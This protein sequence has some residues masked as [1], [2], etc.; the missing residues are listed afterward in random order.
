MAGERLSMQEQMQRRR[1]GGFVGRRD[2]LDTF[3]ANLDTDPAD[4]AHQF[5]FHVRGPGGVGKSTLLGRLE[6]TAGER[7]ALTATVN[8]TA[9]TVPETMGAVAARLAEQ[10]RPLKAF[11]RLLAAYHERRHDAESAGAAPPSAGSTIAAQVGLAGLGLVPGVG[12]LAGAVEPG[13]IAQGADR[14]RAALSARFR[15][16]QDVQLVLDPVSV[17][18]PVFTADLAAAA[19]GARW[20]TLFFDTYE[21]TGPVLDNW[22]CDLLI[23]GRYGALPANIVVTLAGQSALDRTVWADH[24]DLVTTLPL[25]PFTDAEARQVLAARGVTEEAVVETVLRLTGRLPLLV[26]TLAA[27]R[28]SGPGA[29]GDPADTA[30]ERFLKWERDPA[31]RAAA[32]AAALPLRLDEDVY[33]IAVAE[34]APEAADHYDW[35]RG[36]PFVDERSGHLRYHDIVRAQMLRLRRT[37][38]PQR[39]RDQHERLAAAFGVWRERAEDG[40]GVSELWADGTWREHR[41]HESYH[42]LCADHRTAL[43]DTLLDVARACTGGADTARHWIRMLTDA[44]QDTG[45]EELGEWARDLRGALDGT[46]GGGA[47]AQAPTARWRAGRAVHAVTVILERGGL[48]QARRATAQAIRAWTNLQAG[49]AQAA[50][51]DWDRAEQ[52]GLHTFVLYSERGSTHWSSGQPDQAVADYTRALPLAPDDAQALTTRVRRGGALLAAGRPEE[53]MTDLDAVIAADPGATPARAYR[54][55]ALLRLDRPADALADAEECLAAT[56]QGADDLALRGL[57]HQRLGHNAEAL[58]DFDHSLALQPDA[59]TW[60]FTGRGLA[61]EALGR[62]GEAADSFARAV[63]SGESA[64]A[65]TLAYYARVL[66]LAGR[67]TEALTVAE[68]AA[69]QHPGAA[70]PVREAAV[71]LYESG[72][73]PDAA[74]ALR[75]LLDLDPAAGYAL[76]SLALI[77]ARLGQPAAALADLDR[78]AEI[79]PPPPW[80]HARR[81]QLHVLLRD[82]AAARDELGALERDRALGVDELLT[83]AVCHREQRRY[84]DAAAVLARAGALE[85]GHDGVALE[86]AMLAALTDGFPAARG[87]WLAL[88]AA[89]EPP[90]SLAANAPALW[91]MLL[92]CGLGEWDAAGTHV[93]ALLAT[94]PSWATLTVLARDVAALAAAPAGHPDRLAPLLTRLPT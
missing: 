41:L 88:R 64:E 26:S 18:S 4:E 56:A 54:A 20:L 22:L 90:G 77:H 58:A 2:E 72:R 3:R 76:E 17:L 55:M 32:L 63:G 87:R 10:G 51:A 5:L 69:A 44:A 84:A 50:L 38:S 48:D 21:R 73:L 65:E 46:S 7:G 24:L 29:V 28:P 35:L 61:L 37:R 66:R 40:R 1:R 42:A 86:G 93:T 68:R 6:R 14:L 16:E 62:F 15:N 52:L 49:D 19:G 94:S 74:D 27:T 85:P 80:F 34:D 83:L 47:G 8:E 36:L 59:E 45:A 11:D 67:H 79:G 89:G 82:M 91:R 33:R 31:G 43:P 75:R 60:V 71:S 53:A 57:I 12:A 70:G 23:E 13:Q 81:A 30:V 25:D 92:A 39:W 9:M 78:L